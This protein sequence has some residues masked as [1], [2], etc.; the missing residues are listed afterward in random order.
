MAGDK[1]CKTRE[2]KT[3]STAT[4]HRKRAPANNKKVAIQRLRTKVVM[5]RPTTTI[6]VVMPMDKVATIKARTIDKKLSHNQ[7]ETE[8]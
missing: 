2:M 3:V 1:M 5:A 8:P 7:V 6:K 4:V